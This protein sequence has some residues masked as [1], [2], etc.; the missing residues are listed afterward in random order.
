MGRLN[1]EQATRRRD[2]RGDCGAGGGVDRA[3]KITE[4]AGYGGGAIGTAWAC[5]V[6][7][8]R[9]GRRARSHPDRLGTAGALAFRP[10]SG[11][12]EV[13]WRGTGA[14]VT[15]QPAGRTSAVGPAK[16]KTRAAFRSAARVRDDERAACEDGGGAVVAAAAAGVR[17]DEVARKPTG[18]VLERRRGA[19]VVYALRF[20]AY[21]RRRYLTLG[22]HAEGWTRVRAEEELQNVLADVRRGLW[23]PPRADRRWRGRA[24]VPRVRL[25]LVRGDQRTRDCAQTRCSTT[26]GS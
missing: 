10:G 12:R 24:D 14:G 18:E 16:T 20:R 1:R 4:A 7:D 2:D 9:E 5:S 21:G 11:C 8:L 19:T 13:G 26:S 23:Q 17:S 25:R 15:S 3:A 6:D 22:T